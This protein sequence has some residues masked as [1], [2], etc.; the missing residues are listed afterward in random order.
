MMEKTKFLL[1][2]F[3]SATSLLMATGNPNPASDINSIK[4]GD[5]SIYNP[6]PSVPISLANTIFMSMLISLVIAPPIIKIIVPFI[7]MFVL[8]FIVNYIVNCNMN[9][10]KNMILE[11]N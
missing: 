3:S 4:V 6:M 9:L 1:F 5:I 8:I 10:Q 11:K 2:L 7:K